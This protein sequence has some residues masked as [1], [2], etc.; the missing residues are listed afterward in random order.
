MP[1]EKGQMAH[2]KLTKCFRPRSAKKRPS[3]LTLSFWLS[4]N[5]IADFAEVC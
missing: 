4:S 2:P 3:R 5:F 1:L